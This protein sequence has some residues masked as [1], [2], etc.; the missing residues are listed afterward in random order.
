MAVCDGHGEWCRVTGCVCALCVRVVRTAH[1]VL[2]AH[3]CALGVVV[4]RGDVG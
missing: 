1:G 3:G 4:T 2:C